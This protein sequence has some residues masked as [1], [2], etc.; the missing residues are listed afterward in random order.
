MAS[1]CPPLFRLYAAESAG[2]VDKADN[3]TMEFLRL[4]HQ[5]QGFAISLGM[6]HGEVGPLVFFNGFPLEL[7]DHRHRSSAQGGNAAYNGA[8]IAVI[9]VSMQFD[10]LLKGQGI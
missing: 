10:E 7:A 2:G 4:P 6:G 1:P 8:I 3:R 5:P 9:T